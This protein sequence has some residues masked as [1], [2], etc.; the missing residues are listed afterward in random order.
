MVRC[1]VKS[2]ER[3]EFR[4]WRLGWVTST[5]LGLSS[6]DLSLVA[7]AV[8]DGDKVLV[9]PSR[10]LTVP[11]PGSGRWCSPVLEISSLH[12]SRTRSWQLPPLTATVSWW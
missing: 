11:P 6:S 4:S 10:Q 12:P 5:S 2:E 9:T 8:V 3:L 7:V 1:L